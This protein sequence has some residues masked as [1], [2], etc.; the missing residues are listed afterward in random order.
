VR[1]VPP[2]QVKHSQGAPGPGEGL[3]EQANTN[4]VPCNY[5]LSLHHVGG[6]GYL[7]SHPAYLL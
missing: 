6:Q 3:Q 5:Q 2:A 1:Y 4:L 7:S